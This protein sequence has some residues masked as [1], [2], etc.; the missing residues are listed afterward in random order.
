MR[1]RGQGHLP[2][3]KGGNR[4]FVAWLGIGALFVG[5][6]ATMDQDRS[7]GRTL[8]AWVVAPAQANRPSRRSAAEKAVEDAQRA[9]A[10]QRRMQ[11][12]QQADALQKRLQN[13][14]NMVAAQQKRML[15]LQQVEA[16]QKMQY[17]QQMQAAAQKNI[18]QM[19]A[20]A[21]KSV[22]QPGVA[23]KQPWSG[24]HALRRHNDASP[25]SKSAPPAM[26]NPAAV[27]QRHQA[28]IQQMMARFKHHPGGPNGNQQAH[29]E[30]PGN[31]YAALLGAMGRH[32]GSPQQAHHGHDRSRDR[33]DNGHHQSRHQAA[34]EALRER[35]SRHHH[36]KDTTKQ[37]TPTQ[38]A[39]TPTPTTTATDAS[40]T[41]STTKTT[42]TTTKGTTPGVSLQLPV[43]VPVVSN[44]GNGVKLP[45]VATV[46]ADAADKTTDWAMSRLGGPQQ[47]KTPDTPKSNDNSAASAAKKVD[48]SP[49][50][51]PRTQKQAGRGLG[52][53]AGRLLPAV[54]SFVKNEV[55]AINLGKAGL[56]KAKALN[57]K[58]LEHRQ[59]DALQY[60][61]TR[62]ETPPVFAAPAAVNNLHE[63]LP[64]D[65]F[66][67]NKVYVPYK[68]TSDA[69]PSSPNT[70]AP[71]KPAIPDS[72]TGR[73][74]PCSAERCYGPAIINW[75][76]QLAACARE[77]KIGVIDTG[78]DA[79]HPAFAGVDIRAP[80]GSMLPPGKTAA[81]SQ[82]G[83]A[84]LSVMA[85]KTSSPTA[86]LVSNATF[87]VANTFFA[88]DYG[89]AMSSTMA[90]VNALNWMKEQ[91]VDVLNLS[92]AGPIDTLV[93]DA[94]KEVAKN[95]TAVLAAV[96][97]DGPK[98]GKNY[99][100][101]YDEVIAVTAVDRNLAVYAHAN[102]GQYVAVA[103][104]G[105]DVWVA[106]PNKREGLQT[107]TSFAVPFATSVVAI[108]YH[109]DLRAI[110]NPMAPKMQALAALQKGAKT[111]GGGR[112]D[113][114]GAG[115][116]QAPSHCDPRNGPAVVAAPPKTSGWGSKVEVAAPAQ[117][118]VAPVPVPNGS[119]APA[120]TTVSN[121][122]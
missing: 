49:D 41:A 74:S 38:T 66:A 115:L 114:F 102:Q 72:P 103:A 8:S 90:M 119:W 48:N 15:M 19:Q 64:G 4:K 93:Q 91:K 87:Y 99:P 118:A 47:P 85:G 40:K 76:P 88:D 67:L 92:F 12:Q 21:Q 27:V 45:E 56:E 61:V 39:V 69:T 57:Y 7:W 22:Q 101:A 65:G 54:E 59:L 46:V 24:H 78:I 60:S 89:N 28:V 50:V 16:A 44:Q 98:A 23:Q 97:N 35:L 58:I 30:S 10:L 73:G 2:K 20:A 84:V 32:K 113:V 29:F 104:P 112:N 34:Y 77:V 36:R 108:S 37:T 70:P 63:A 111:L 96:G 6:I 80:K 86:G 122:K 100:A 26:M 71:I 55:L 95:G 83:T 121:K 117:A 116:V 13:I 120:V 110:G 106:L 1:T 9:E 31:R 11:Q 105:V 53:A 3:A 14:Q 81:S 82:H 94:I 43:E 107:G 68:T 5:S 17:M 75:R 42:T 25:S 51:D 79:N 109:P 52:A 33:S 62:L 18:Q